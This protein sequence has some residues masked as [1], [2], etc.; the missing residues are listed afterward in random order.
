MNYLKRRKMEM[1]HK[2]R[3]SYKLN[4]NSMYL[5]VLWKIATIRTAVDG[6]FLLLFLLKIFD[7]DLN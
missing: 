4:R 2:N 5:T 6:K 1:A 7:L 3:D